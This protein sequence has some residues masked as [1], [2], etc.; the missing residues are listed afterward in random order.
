LNQVLL[1]CYIAL[2]IVSSQL[3]FNLFVYIL[4]NTLD[5]N[6]FTAPLSSPASTCIIDFKLNGCP[7]FYMSLDNDCRGRPTEITFQY[8][9]GDCRQSENVQDRQKHKCT[10]FN[11]GPPLQPGAQSYITVT[12]LGGSDLY[13]AGPV[14]AGEEYTFKV[15]ETYSL[16]EYGQFDTISS[17]MTITIFESKGGVTLQTIDIKL[18]CS[19][20]LFLG[21][22]FGS[23]QIMQWVEPS[24]RVVSM[25]P[26]YTT[27]SETE[28]TIQVALD[29]SDEQNPVRILEM[30]IDTNTQDQS[31]DYTSQVAG[32]ILQPG[33]SIQLPGFKIDTDIDM[34]VLNQYTF[35]VTII[36]ESL[37]GTN[38]CDGNN[39][40]ECIIGSDP[41]T[42]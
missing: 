27:S 2:S 40:H 1:F 7:K 28:G 10:D 5:D 19:Q 41:L 22:K 3:H 37:D 26:T 8:N 12:A 15:S 23:N 25:M 6:N 24:G 21:D 33:S 38:Q 29:V 14:K 20:P 11:G 16:N 17:D 35:F 39:K 34:D 4:P 42:L 36:G 31:I 9:G 30:I 32:T 18:S 13:F